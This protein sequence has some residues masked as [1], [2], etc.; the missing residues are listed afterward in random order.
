MKPELMV[1]K[2]ISVK[3]TKMSSTFYIFFFILSLSFS[4][5]SRMSA[6]IPH[7]ATTGK[8]MYVHHTVGDRLS[9]LSFDDTDIKY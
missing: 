2:S 7:G 5:L 6:G 9:E 3:L 4:G 8:T 1:V